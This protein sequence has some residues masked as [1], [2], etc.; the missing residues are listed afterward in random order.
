MSRAMNANTGGTTN[1]ARV[2]QDDEPATEYALPSQVMQELLPARTAT[3]RTHVYE[4]N[5]L[6]YTQNETQTKYHHTHE[7]AFFLNHKGTS[8]H[9]FDPP[10]PLP[11][12]T[13]PCIGPLT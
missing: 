7:F 2:M 4:N 5:T 8:V 12:P 10:A 11:H 13:A 6:K 3:Q 1:A 9:K